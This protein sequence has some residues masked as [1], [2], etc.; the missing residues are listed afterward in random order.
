[1]SRFCKCGQLVKNGQ[2][3]TK[4]VVSKPYKPTQ[5]GWAWDVMSR[6]IREQRPLCEHCLEKGKTS[7]TKCVHHMVAVADNPDRL[8]DETNVV[9]LCTECHKE[10]HGGHFGPKK[11]A[12]YG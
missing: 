4:C 3:C 1:M 8:L 10:E 12:S 7:A 5:Y 9:A 11:G 6:R 2:S